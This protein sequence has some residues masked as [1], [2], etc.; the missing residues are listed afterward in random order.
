MLLGPALFYFLLTRGKNTYKSLEIYGPVRFENGARGIDTIYHIAADFNLSDQKGNRVS[1][2]AF[3]NKIYV[4]SIHQSNNTTGTA[5]AKIQGI[6]YQYKA[7]TNL[8]FVSILKN[9]S[10]TADSLALKY[11]AKYGKWLFAEADSTINNDFFK[12][13]FV[14]NSD[15]IN[16]SSNVVLLDETKRVRGFYDATDAWDIA[17]LGDEIKVLEFERFGKVF[18]D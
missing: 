11:R 15:S 1:L 5:L 14:S 10:L 3:P 17:K 9:Q 8:V 7:D 6:V 13:Y 4:V 2:S 16:T 12:S 18:R